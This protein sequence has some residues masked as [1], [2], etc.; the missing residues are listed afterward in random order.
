[1]RR[2][3]LANA[4]AD[5]TEAAFYEA[6]NRADVDA[7]M[8]LWAD[9]DEIVCIHPGAPRMVGHAA[10]RDSWEAV[11]SSGNLHI[12]PIRVHTIH[13]MMLAV[14]TVIEDIDLEQEDAVNHLVASNVYAKTPR[15]WRIVS[16]HV[17]VAPGRGST[18]IRG[19]PP[20]AGL[21]H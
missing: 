7:I 19:V 16:H 3:T 14:H 1:M 15:G 4:S 18:E 21:L 6:V 20:G 2:Q 13:Y 17:S 11:F 12:H 10:I 5:D 9:D 8:A